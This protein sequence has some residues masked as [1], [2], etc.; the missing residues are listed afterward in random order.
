MCVQELLDE[1]LR[2]FLTALRLS[3]NETQH[4]VCTFETNMTGILQQAF[5]NNAKACLP[6]EFPRLATAKC[7]ML[8]FVIWMTCVNT[9]ADMLIM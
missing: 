6:M 2:E 4:A 7:S 9:C 3:M 5:G 1:V 8:C